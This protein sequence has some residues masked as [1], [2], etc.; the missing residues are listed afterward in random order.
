MTQSGCSAAI[1]L[2]VATAWFEPPAAGEKMISAPYMR[3]SW[4]RSDET[5][6]GMTHTSR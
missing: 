3:S 5:F 4:T 6:S 1:C 2:A